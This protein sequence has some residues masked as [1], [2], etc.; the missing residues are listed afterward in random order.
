[1]ESVR[2]NYTSVV[3]AHRLSTIVDADRIIVLDQGHIVEEGTHNQLLQQ[4][5]QYAKLWQLQHDSHQLA[6]TISG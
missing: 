2:G 1:M 4:K 5:G 3:I 6:D